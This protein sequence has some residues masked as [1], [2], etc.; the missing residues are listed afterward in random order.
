MEAKNL[1]INHMKNL[2]VYLGILLGITI[3]S[4]FAACSKDDD[5]KKYSCECLVT[6]D[7]TGETLTV[8]MGQGSKECR[9]LS[10]RDI[11]SHVGGD[12]TDSS[13]Y[14]WTCYEK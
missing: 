9:S 2:S 11:V 6:W 5:E 1:I 3:V 10:F 14:H 4:V 7:V 8:S 13:K 12:E